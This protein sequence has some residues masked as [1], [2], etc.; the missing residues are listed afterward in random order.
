MGEFSHALAH[1]VDEEKVPR[2]LKGG[3]LFEHVR[4]QLFTALEFGEYTHDEEA[5]KKVAAS[6][7][8]KAARAI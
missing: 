7:I 2:H 6:V 8:K 3:V 4:P 5:T 1:A